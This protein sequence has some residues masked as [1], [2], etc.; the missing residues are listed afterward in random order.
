MWRGLGQHLMHRS[1]LLGVLQ[2]NTSPMIV[3]NP[4]LFDLLEGSKA[5]EAGKVIVQ[6]AISY[7]RGLSGAVGITH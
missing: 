7:A 2:N 4:P 3:H 6:A 5:A 1:S